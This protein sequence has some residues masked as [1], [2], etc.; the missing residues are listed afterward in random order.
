M[1]GKGLGYYTS[2]GD[3]V[4]LEALAGRIMSNAGLEALAGRGGTSP[5]KASRQPGFFIIHYSL[6]IIHYS[7]Y[8]LCPQPIPLP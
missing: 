6:F 8:P 2:L 1:D 3:N 7:L 5:A 4:G